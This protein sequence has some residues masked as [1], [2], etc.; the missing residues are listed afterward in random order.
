MPDHVG[1][2]GGVGQ[3]GVQFG[4]REVRGEHGG[5]LRELVGAPQA[6]AHRLARGGDQFG[7]GVQDG[8]D[9]QALP[10]GPRPPARRVDQARQGLLPGEHAADG[11]EAVEVAAVEQRLAH[12]QRV[13]DAAQ[14]GGALVGREHGG[15][16][17]DGVAVHRD[18]RLDTRAQVRD[19]GRRGVVGER[20][21]R[22]G[23]AP[24]VGDGPRC[25]QG[26][27]EVFLGRGASDGVERLAAVE[28]VLGVLGEG[29]RVPA[30]VPVEVRGD[31][32]ERGGAVGLVQVR[33]QVERLG[34]QLGPVVAGQR[35]ERHGPVGRGQAADGALDRRLPARRV[36]GGEGEG[37]APLVG[38]AV[39]RGVEHL[40]DDG[41]ALARVQCGQQRGQGQRPRAG[42]VPG[43]DAPRR[44]QRP[45]ERWSGEVPADVG[46]PQRDAPGRVLGD[47][48]EDPGEGAVPADRV[49]RGE[50]RQKRRFVV[51]HE[52]RPVAR[53]RG[54]FGGHVV[55]E[56]VRVRPVPGVPQ[57]Q[58]PLRGGPPVPA[59]RAARDERMRA[60][61]ARSGEVRD[62]VLDRARGGPLLVAH[63]PDGVEQRVGVLAP[64]H[65][66]EQL[67][68]EDRPS[69]L[70]RRCSSPQMRSRTSAVSIG[71][72]RA[73]SRKPP[74]ARGGN[75]LSHA[76]AAS[77]AVR[78]SA[79]SSTAVTSATV[80]ASSSTA[81]TWRNAW[82]GDHIPR[83]TSPRTK[84]GASGAEPIAETAS[85]LASMRA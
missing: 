83:A 3:V 47:A 11:G 42:G 41:G 14:Q 36:L 19:V 39:V 74:W 37:R 25:A 29:E 13:G 79:P 43:G 45:V 75:T 64:G 38:I 7:R 24:P 69:A 57:R 71:S 21:Q 23:L 40:L 81:L 56:P 16:Q 35:G 33:D 15:E 6:L 72:S 61:D 10:A 46:E 63:G 55:G 70:A 12:R 30:G 68:G 17:D 18:A 84:P 59:G 82:E 67:R 50:Q 2:V 44:A 65:G 31:G 53:Q 78:W 60:S 9:V 49:E 32:D 51:D 66:A 8:P 62:Q 85:T 34:A 52:A 4:H 54:E 1:Q 27:G 80:R 5:P 20:G 58:R 28:G 48:V 73:A 77:S 76:I 22:P 26:V